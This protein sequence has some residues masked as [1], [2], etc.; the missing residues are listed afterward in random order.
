MVSWTTVEKATRWSTLTKPAKRKPAGFIELGELFRVHRGQVTG[1]N[2][3]WIAGPQAKDI[4]AQYLFPAVTRAREIISQNGTLETLDQLRSVIDLPV[5]LDELTADERRKVDGF[6]KWA[7]QNGA[8]ETYIAKNRRAWWAVGLRDAPPILCTYMARRAPV[9][10][11]NSAGARYL[12]IAHGLYP[13]Q[14]MTEKELASVLRYL[15]ETVGVSSGRTYAGGLTKFE[16][17]EV[18]RLHIPTQAMLGQESGF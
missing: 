15:R 17:G 6:L 4:P 13:R 5:D 11:R 8:H 1:M 12:N 2:A 3:I 10:I 18:Q 16:P 14:A 7:S 9:F